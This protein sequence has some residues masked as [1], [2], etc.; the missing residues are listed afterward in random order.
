LMLR[1][2]GYR[3]KRPGP[4]LRLPPAPEALFLLPEA[5]E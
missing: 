2:L 1:S 4:A 5:S 3:F